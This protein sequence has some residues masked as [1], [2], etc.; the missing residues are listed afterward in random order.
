MSFHYCPDCAR[1]TDSAITVTEPNRGVF[2]LDD[3]GHEVSI[4]QQWTPAPIQM[5]RP[6][7]PGETIADRVAE[8]EPFPRGVEVKVWPPEDPDDE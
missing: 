2:R 4:T 7:A 3:C 5:F 1:F 6:L 8:Q